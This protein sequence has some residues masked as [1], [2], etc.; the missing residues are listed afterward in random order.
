M[1]RIFISYRRADSDAIAGRIR[2]R[3][4]NHFGEQSVFM[5]IDSIPF[6]T[7]F[8]THIKEM[9]S[10]NDIL[11]SIIGPQWLGSENDGHF[12]IADETDPIRV[13]LETALKAGSAVIPVLVGGAKMPKPS[14][15]PDTLKDF[16]YRNA[17][18]VDVGRDFHHHMQRLIRSMETLLARSSV[19]R[20]AEL[21]EEDAARPDVGTETPPHGATST[22]ESE[23]ASFVKVSD[24][25]AVAAT[26]APDASPADKP[27]PRHRR[28]WLIALPAVCIVVG[29]GTA[30]WLYLRVW[31]PVAPQVAPAPIATPAPQPTPPERAPTTLPRMPGGA[32]A[33]C[34]RE[35]LATFTDDF[36]LEDPAWLASRTDATTLYYA[37]GQLALS[38]S[39][40]KYVLALY[41]PLRFKNFSICATLKGPAQLGVLDGG[42]QGGVAFW[43]EDSANFYLA[44]IY[45]N[46]TYSIYR[47]VDRAWHQI[48]ARTALEG[49]KSGVSATNEVQVTAS[50]DTATLYINGAKVQEFRGQPP[51]NPSMIGLYGGSNSNERNEWRVQGVAIT[52]LDLPK[53]Q[54]NA[55]APTP[56]IELGCKPLRPAAFQDDFKSHDPGWGPMQE[57]TAFFSDGELVLK[58]P[59]HTSRR[60]MYS[61]LI[62]KNA[63]VCARVK[64]PLEL[65]SVTNGGLAFWS[66]NN[67]THYTANVYPDGK[68]AIYRLFNSQWAALIPPTKSEH[69]RAEPRAVNEIM[70]AFNGDV[71]IVYL[72]GRNVSQVR[73][74]PP[75]RGGSIGVFAANTD[76]AESDWHFLDV[77][78]VDNE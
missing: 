30:A 65:N 19:S 22:R 4:A 31:Q 15:L 75:Q 28:L 57:G 12:R 36:Q 48:A 40:G 3:L 9:L 77:V 78:V 45:T 54:A 10:H 55:K 66:I 13:E 33:G 2:D 26:T 39:E 51:K 24:A 42:A 21:K 72:N 6:G 11:V 68:F 8:R 23:P 63:T 37:D 43:A 53:Q 34:N 46:G 41:R 32:S 38:G 69:V 5:D 25:P 61:S 27:A 7:D 35:G 74:Q 49:I 73:G 20:A 71:A 16:S 67:N 56:Q 44:T 52:D 62:F 1:P 50:G 14:E 60:Q 18:E 58:P 70:I 64:S 76:A 47:Q 29:M 59:V 17:A